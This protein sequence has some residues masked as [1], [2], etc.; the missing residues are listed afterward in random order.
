MRGTARERRK[1]REKEG[2]REAKKEVNLFPREFLDPRGGTLSCELSR[3]ARSQRSSHHNA[4]RLT[5]GP[6]VLQDKERR[7]RKGERKRRMESTSES[8][9]NDVT[10]GRKKT[11]DS[12]R[13]E[14][15]QRRMKAKRLQ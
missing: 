14:T 8:E 12:R 3:D 15:I 4:R 2:W 7:N 9:K 1:E 6:Q 10:S 13:N 11:K 5:R